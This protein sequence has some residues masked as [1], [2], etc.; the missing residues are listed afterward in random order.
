MNPNGRRRGEERGSNSNPTDKWD[1]QS[2][3]Y[4]LWLSGTGEALRQHPKA[5]IDGVRHS[6]AQSHDGQSRTWGFRQSGAS[7]T[8][9]IN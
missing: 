9:A 7:Q 3:G 2:L 1:M 6:A 8:T 4:Q 5:S